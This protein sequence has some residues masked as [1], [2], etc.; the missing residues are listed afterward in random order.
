MQS[1]VKQLTRKLKGYKKM[2]QR[3]QEPGSGV[4][5]SRLNISRAMRGR[6]PK[7]PKFPAVQNQRNEEQAASHSEL[8]LPPQPAPLS[9]LQQVV[10]GAPLTKGKRTSDRNHRS[11]SYYGFDNSSSDSSI[12]VPPKRSR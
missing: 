8:I 10:P 5:S 12:A 6:I 7:I 3:R 1:H 9:A 4:L 2:K 11:P